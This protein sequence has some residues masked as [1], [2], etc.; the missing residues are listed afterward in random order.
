LGRR[1]TAEINVPPGIRDDR[2]R[3]SNRRIYARD[4][5]SSH[6]GVTRDGGNHKL[7]S[8]GWAKGS[9][10]RQQEAQ[11]EGDASRHCSPLLFVQN[12]FFENQVPLELA[13]VGVLFRY[14]QDQLFRRPNQSPDEAGPATVRALAQ[15]TTVETESLG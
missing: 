3:R 5:R 1:G 2:Q 8:Q 15:D 4:W 12:L 10:T 9:A 6:R 11:S 7:L 14:L 13:A